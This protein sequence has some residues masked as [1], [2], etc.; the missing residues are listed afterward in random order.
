[1]KLPSKRLISS[2]AV[3]LAVGIVL[4]L[5]GNWQPSTASLNQKSSVGFR[6]PFEGTASAQAAPAIT[7]LSDK[8]FKNVKV[9]TGVPVDD[10]MGEMGLYSAALSMCCGD[11]HVGAGT[12]NPDWASD[13]NPRK[14]IARNMAAMVKAINKEHFGGGTT[15]TCWTCHRGSGNPSQTA[16]I[17]QVYGDPLPFP[18]DVMRAAPANTGVPTLDQIFDKYYKALGGLDKVNALKSY[19]ATGKSSLYGETHSDP[20]EVY[21]KAPGSLSVVVHVSGGDSVRT[22][23][24]V[25][26][27]VKLPLTVVKE[28]PFTDGRLE[29]GKLD[30]IVA[31]PGEIKGYFTNWRV[32]FATSIDDKPV[33]AIQATGKEGLLASFYF[34]KETGL[35]TRYVRMVPTALGRVP[36]QIDYSDYKPV[37]GVMMPHSWIYGWISGR[38]QY[39]MDSYQPNVAIDASKF[40]EPMLVTK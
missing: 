10:F 25:H 11:C 16:S 22:T 19:V 21:A 38:E 32:S 6:L 23:D 13:K 29:G 37:A 33:W 14:V 17:D 18:T 35:L 36:T 28:Y 5:A 7:Q 4:T 9:I 8:Y 30:A 24:G 12:D 1:M 40:S 15:I 39:V 31:F 27:W 26:A 34:D 3:G 2:G 20:A